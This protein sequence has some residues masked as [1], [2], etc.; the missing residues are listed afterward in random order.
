MDDFATRLQR[1][2]DYAKVPRGLAGK[3]SPQQLGQR[4]GVER[5]KANQW[6]K[7]ASLPEA[8]MV[9]V[10]ADAL[11]VDARWLITGA[12][13]M[14]P[15]PQGA[16][17]L[18]GHERDLL[19]RYRMS[20]P[21]WRLAIHLLS[22]VATEEDQVEAAGDINM[23]LARIFGKKPRDIKPV[24]NQRVEQA[25]GSAPHVRKRKERT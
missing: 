16:S 11:G 25:Y 23:V 3:F 14:V 12:E 2:A 9:F 21:R 6:L 10:I 5:G 20:D 8:G 7:G 24:S 18:E 13:P 15:P 19:A 17:D 4:I 1:A 22:K